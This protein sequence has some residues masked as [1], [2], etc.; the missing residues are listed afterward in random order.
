VVYRNT[1]NSQ[2]AKA[3]QADPESLF[4][5]LENIEDFLRRLEIYT[6][7]APNQGMVDIIT[8]IMVE[9]LNILAIVTKEIKQGRMSKSFAVTNRFPLMKPFLEKYLTKLIKKLFGKNDIE[10]A[11][12]TLDRLTQREARM[13]SV[14]ALKTTNAINRRV[15]EIAD[16]V[17]GVEN[18]VIDGAQY[19]FYLLS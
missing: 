16:I 1:D 13:A 12:K 5:M 11:L 19:I 7:V 2:T 8:A 4:E 3:V 9:V 6:E 18:V 14:Q 10:D 15:E 17:L